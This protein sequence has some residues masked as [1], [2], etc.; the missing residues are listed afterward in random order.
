MGNVSMDMLRNF[1]SAVQGCRQPEILRKFLHLVIQTGSI[2]ESGS[3]L[4]YDKKDGK[5]HSFQERP[6]FLDPMQCWKKVLDLDRS[7]AGLAFETRLLQYSDDVMK[8]K[9]VY[10]FDEK[11]QVKSMVCVPIMLRW[12]PKP[13][14]VACFHNG[15]AGRVFDEETR[16]TITVSVSVLELALQVAGRIRSN[17]VFIVHGRDER[18]LDKLKLFLA[19]R[20]VQFVVLGDQAHLGSEILERLQSII[21]DCS[22]GFV[23]LTPDDEARIRGTNDVLEPRARQNVIF[24]A[25]WL[26]G[27]FRE[28]L[29]ICFLKTAPMELP[30]DIQGV[31]YEKFDVSQPDR[32][33]L[34]NILT[35]WGVEWKRLAS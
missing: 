19:E 30:S 21:D 18:A 23:L 3:I 6:E 8:D 5:L 25:G 31:L 22:A 14:G 1:L 10:P 33:R 9:R 29:K 2:C 11:E 20:Q 4:L 32:F 12:L 17:Q 28:E 24:E 13:Y 35:K 15:T 7:L 16:H 26:A 34:E 27:V